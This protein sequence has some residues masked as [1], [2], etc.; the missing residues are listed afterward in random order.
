LNAFGVYEYMMS[1]NLSRSHCTEHGRWNF[2]SFPCGF[3]DIGYRGK[4]NL[5]WL[6]MYLV[7]NWWT[8][9]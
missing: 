7:L 4:E 8:T 1:R 6:I 9:Q 3:H 5:L 2:T